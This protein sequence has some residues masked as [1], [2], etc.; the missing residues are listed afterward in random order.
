MN[1]H[2]IEGLKMTEFSCCY[3]FQSFLLGAGHGKL[4]RI[5]INSES[6]M[7]VGD[8]YVEPPWKE[9]Q[10]NRKAFCTQPRLMA[11]KFHD[12]TGRSLRPGL[13]IGLSGTKQTPD[14]LWNL[15]CSG[16]VVNITAADQWPAGQNICHW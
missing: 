8:G 15:P 1:T 14:Y 16:V 6:K 2:R 11:G 10:D 7:L 12:H 5:L 13:V 3:P 9:A 4:L